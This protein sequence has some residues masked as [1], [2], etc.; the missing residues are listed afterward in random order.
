[1]KILQIGKFY[2][3]IPGGMETILRT[4]SEGLAAA[5]HSVTVVCAGAKA[6]RIEEKIAGVRVIRL[7]Y[8]GKLLSQPLTPTLPLELLREA[9]SSDLVNVHTP[10]PLAE[11]SSLALPSRIPLVVSYHSEIVRQKA[12]LPLMKPLLNRELA[13]ARSIVVATPRH[14]SESPFLSRIPEKCAVIPY[15]IP[16]PPPEPTP[17]VTAQ[18]R[19]LQDRHGKFVLFVG[20]LVGYKGVSVLIRAMKDV[21]ANLVV[22]GAGPM[23]A[24][25]ENEARS[26]GLEARIRFEGFVPDERLEPYFRSCECLV[27]PSI[28]VNEAF[29]LVQV[30]AM[31]CSK[32]TIAT[33]LESGITEVNQPGVTGLLVPPSDPVALASAIRE[34]LSDSQRSREMGAA[35]RRRYEERFTRERMVDAYQALYGRLL[36]SSSE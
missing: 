20:R 26:L 4:L 6:R 15:G 18:A 2:S 12:L 32:P 7:P 34:L 28:S 30:E 22:V 14:V 24:E 5:G 31:A 17:E 29:G 1:M 9:S 19:A 27:L 35:A 3:P 23:R 21:G 13:R 8:F 25:L 33:Q 10:N 36:A 16:S 11:L